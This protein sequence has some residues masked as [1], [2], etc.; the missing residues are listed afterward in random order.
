MSEL[1]EKA[2]KSQNKNEDLNDSK[3]VEEVDQDFLLA[4]EV[5]KSQEAKL[6]FRVLFFDL[7]LVIAVVLNSVKEDNFC[8]FNSVNTIL[9]LENDQTLIY[10]DAEKVTLD[11]VSSMEEAWYK[12]VSLLNGLIFNPAGTEYSLKAASSCFEEDD[13]ADLDFFQKPIFILT[14]NQVLGVYFMTSEFS[15]DGISDKKIVEFYLPG[16]YD[17][18]RFKNAKETNDAFSDT[19]NLSELDLKTAIYNDF[20]ELIMLIEINFDYQGIGTLTKTFRARTIRPFL[21]WDN[22][23]FHFTQWFLFVMV[24]AAAINLVFSIVVIAVKLVR[25]IRIGIETKSFEYKE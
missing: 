2:K 6:S 16:T 18:N 10:S 17:G 20:L 9:N 3:L 13:Y 24:N 14:F 7:M 19:T 5:K 4:T 22:E 23:H 25:L 15:E 12:M 11:E 8:F 1:F 21:V